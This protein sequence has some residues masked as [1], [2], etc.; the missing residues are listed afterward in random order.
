[1]A[2]GNTEMFELFGSVSSQHDRAAYARSHNAIRDPGNSG[3]EC[4]HDDGRAK[5]ARSGCDGRGIA[6]CDHKTRSGNRHGAI[7]GSVY[8]GAVIG[9]L[10]VATD[11]ASACGIGKHGSNLSLAVAQWGA[12]Y[13]LAIHPLIMAHI[14]RHPEVLAP[15]PHS[16][17]GLKANTA[18]RGAR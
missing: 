15:G 8:L 2:R 7:L 4:Q 12:R 9:S 5:D 14:L 6:W 17:L 13:R 18:I 10:M 1:M 16:Y 3:G 11:A